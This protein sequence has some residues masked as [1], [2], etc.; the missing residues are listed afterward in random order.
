MQRK[1]RRRKRKINTKFEDVELFSLK[2]TVLIVRNTFGAN[3]CRLFDVRVDM[4][5]VN[6]EW[7]GSA[8]GL[9]IDTYDATE[10]K[11]N[12]NKKSYDRV[13]LVDLIIF[14]SSFVTNPP[15]KNTISLELTNAPLPQTK[16]STAL[17]LITPVHT[18]IFR[19]YSTGA[20]KK[21]LTE[22]GKRG[23]IEQKRTACGE[24]VHIFIINFEKMTRIDKHSFILDTWQ[25]CCR[26]CRCSLLCCFF[27]SSRISMVFVRVVGW[28]LACL[29]GYVNVCMCFVVFLRAV[30]FDVS[31]PMSYCWRIHS[32]RLY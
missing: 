9:E 25:C 20:R 5:V 23:E 8:T 24:K 26:R 11:M 7:R 2:R 22:N 19:C 12:Q 13:K 3:N 21:H 30:S 17:V 31:L 29:F 10:V 6:F 27:L 14:R 32:L 28:L 18:N 16:M 1:W 4:K 15:K